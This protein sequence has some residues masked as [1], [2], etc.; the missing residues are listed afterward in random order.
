[1]SL[2]ISTLSLENR[3]FI[4]LLILS[5]A[6]FLRL[7]HLGYHD[8]WYDEIFTV[9]Y[10][11]YPWH[12][13][14]APLY[15]ILLHPWIKIFGVSEFSLR[16][17]SLLFSFLSVI[18]VFIL[19]KAL[20]NKKVGMMASAFMGLSPF[21]LW[22]AQEARD[23]S[24]VLF[25][26]LFSTWIFY[27]ALREGKDKFW[28]FFILISLIGLYTNYFYIFL[29]L[30]QGLYI[31]VL[32]KFR[33]NFK[34]LICYLIIALGFSFYLRPFLSKFY[35]IWQGFWIPKPTWH[36]LLVT[37]ENFVLGYNGA[38]YLYSIS[39]ILAASFFVS[40]FW[41]IPKVGAKQNLILCISLC[42]IP[43][44]CAFFFS[45]VF[46][47]VYLDR[48]LIIFSPYYYLIL[49]LGMVYLNRVI[50]IPLLIIFILML[51]VADYRYFKDWMIMP[52]KHHTGTHIKKP[53]KP[54]VKF[55]EDNIE[56]QDIIAFTNESVMPSIRFYRQR[57]IPLFYYFF[58]PRFY[59]SSWRRPIQESP[60]NVSFYKINDLKFKRLWV[61][62]SDW[63]RSGR[64]D[65]N[66]QSVKN[67][68]DKN[69][70]L[71]FL[72]EFD[73]LWI[74]RYGRKDF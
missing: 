38:P 8:F 23:Y 54:V 18:L 71:E 43:I 4:I 61:I 59:D 1:M 73:G 24:M 14:N 50:K 2:R 13:W 9:R 64:L 32:R 25:L 56:P 52:L 31:I 16:F 57:I 46:F 12:N 28:L 22:Y 26:G 36:S 20:F 42:F 11:Q 60:Y 74:F 34:E 72:R 47:S 65:K 29:L 21:H 17:P 3:K 39:N 55:L 41:R 5:T 48:C 58:D 19:G 27:K 35:Y 33:L 62:S 7:Y 37:L 30:A 44:I 53:I 6:F 45:K 67:W 49:S 10:A 15:W 70:K 40:V 66:S 69:L 68:L 51:L 63:A